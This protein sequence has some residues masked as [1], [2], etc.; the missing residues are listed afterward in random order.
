LSRAYVGLGANMGN[1]EA[2]LHRAV[3]LLGLTPG[4]RLVGL[5][6][7]RETE[8]VGFVDQPRFLNGAVALET[9]LS[10]RA[11]LDRLLEIEQELGRKR[12]VPN[13]PR[14][15]DLDLLL[16]DTVQLK[17]PGLELP[18]PRL[19]LRCFA[20]EPLAEL[21]GDLEIPGRGPIQLV[22]RRLHCANVP[23]R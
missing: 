1:R 14:T 2:T 3:E 8:P 20:L 23:S 5:S 19:H 16:Y 21:D 11:V 22:M 17:L 12:T 15:I 10:A 6:T 4:I 7:F 9:E 13:G 18:H